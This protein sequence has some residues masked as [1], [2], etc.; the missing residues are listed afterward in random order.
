MASI[1]YM[2]KIIYINSPPQLRDK[3][4]YITGGS[5]DGNMCNLYT[6]KSKTHKQFYYLGQNAGTYCHS[7]L[8][9]LNQLKHLS[10]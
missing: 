9:L 3:F 1:T 6:N 7:Y 2:F 10:I 8:D 4:V 5:R